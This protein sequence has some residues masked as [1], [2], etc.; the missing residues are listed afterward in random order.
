MTSLALAASFLLLSHFLIASTRLRGQLVR[1]LG[2][3]RYLA[4]YSALTLV[5]FVWLVVAYLRA[6]ALVLWTPPG[7]VTA[8]L[9]PFALLGS[10]LIAAGLSTP[11]PIIVRKGRLFDQPDLVRGIL[12]VSRN[13]FFWGVGLL[14]LAQMIM[15]GEV[16]ALLTFGSIA[17]L[18]IVGS[19]VLDA[20]KAL[21]HREGWRAFA[22]ATSNVPFLAI[23]RGRQHLSLREIGPRRMASGFG[24]LLITLA[25]DALLSSSGMFDDVR[26]AF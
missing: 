4:S 15:L 7:W 5:I 2:E 19:F 10:V 20:K 23:I 16:A 25:F 3:E 24:V 21:Q 22:T 9:L 14:S 12:R 8:G 11:N 26:I 13:P 6:P 17:F 18:G 1:R